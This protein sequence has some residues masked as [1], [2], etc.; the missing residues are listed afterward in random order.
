MTELLLTNS[1]DGNICH[2]GRY[3]VPFLE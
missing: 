1:N 3:E 2:T